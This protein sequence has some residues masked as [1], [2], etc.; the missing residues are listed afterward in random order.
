MELVAARPGSRR[1]AGEAVRAVRRRL[2]RGDGTKQH[3]TAPTT[4][5]AAPSGSTAPLSDAPAPVIASGAVLR[6]RGVSPGRVAAPLRA[7]RAGGRRTGGGPR[8]SLRPTATPR[9]R[10]SS[11]PPWHV[12]DQLRARTSQATGET[13]A[14][15]DASRLLASDPE[16]VSEAT[17]L[18]RSKGRSAARAIWE[19]AAAHE[20]GVAALGG[21]MAER[22]ADNPRRAGPD[23]RR[24]PAGRHARG[25]RAR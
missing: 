25:A 1:G 5:A 4:A 23:H 22:V 12:A 16:L 8:S 14:I 20:K 24:D 2:R 17:A 6:G 15:L 18:V 13:R 19:T 11:G 10:R 7:P 9:S 3:R 21:R